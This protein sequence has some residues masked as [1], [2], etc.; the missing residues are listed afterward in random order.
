MNIAC[1]AIHGNVLEGHYLNI[2][3]PLAYLTLF[4]GIDIQFVPVLSLLGI[5]A[6]E[7]SHS[8]PLNT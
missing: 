3:V 7:P 4:L 6:G 1:L 2:P 5:T 8:L